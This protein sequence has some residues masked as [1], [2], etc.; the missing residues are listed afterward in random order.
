MQLNAGMHSNAVH[1]RI[2][3]TG[4]IKMLL[5][6]NKVFPEFSLFIHG[7]V[8]FEPYQKMFDNLIGKKINSIELYPSSEGFIAYQDRLNEGGLLLLLNLL[9][10]APA[11]GRNAGFI[12]GSSIFSPVKANVCSFPLSTAFCTRKTPITTGI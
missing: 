8:N 7:G 11:G 3:I 1:N 5:D 4:M 12:T 2:W 10:L 9:L 6:I